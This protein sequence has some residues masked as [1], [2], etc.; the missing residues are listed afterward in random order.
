MGDPLEIL[1]K[2]ATVYVP[3]MFALCFHEFAHGWMALKRGDNTAQQMGRL[4]MNP[5][6]HVDMLGTVILPIFAILTNFGIFFGWAKPVPFNP[7]NL[8]NPRIDTFWIALAGPMSN[9]L[10]AVVSSL[11]IFLMVHSGPGAEWKNAVLTLAAKFIQVNLFLAFFNLIPLHPLDGAK[12]LAR[13]LPAQIN[14]KLEQYESASG[15]I[16]MALIV[17]G[18]L[19][20]LIVPVEFTYRLLITMATRGA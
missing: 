9:I 15:M 20:F 12:V 16:L 3:F 17:V 13:F 19:G 4:T 5:M 10:L 14:Y 2:L 1:Y 11:V 8:K 18:A 6:A 7:R